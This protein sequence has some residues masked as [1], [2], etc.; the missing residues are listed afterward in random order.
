MEG[1]KVRIKKVVILLVLTSMLSI[2]S[3]SVF[4]SRLDSSNL[5][6]E[7]KETEISPFVNWTGTAYVVV[8]YYTNVTSSNNFF[9]DRPTVTNHASNPG[10]L[11][12]RIINEKGAV[13]GEPKLV[14]PGTS[15]KLDTIP[16][17]SGTYT[18]QARATSRIGTYYISID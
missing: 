10:A 8:N 17:N 15:V 18:L 3:H 16:W 13:V 11:T 14:A 9:D 2:S 1:N 6:N 4:A 5:V 12:V 7:S